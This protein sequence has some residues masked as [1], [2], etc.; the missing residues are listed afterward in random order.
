MFIAR[1]AIEFIVLLRLRAESSRRRQRLGYPTAQMSPF[2]LRPN[3]SFILLRE[4]AQS[5]PAD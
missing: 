3:S 5:L 1:G 2:G 4:I